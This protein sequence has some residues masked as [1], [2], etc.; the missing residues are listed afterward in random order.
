MQLIQFQ[1]P[2][3][4]LTDICHQYLILASFILLKKAASHLK[5]MAS[6]KMNGFRCFHFFLVPTLFVTCDAQRAP[7]SDVWSAELAECIDGQK[8]SGRVEL[9]VVRV[10]E[11]APLLLYGQPALAR[12]LNSEPSTSFWSLPT[13]PLLTTYP[14]FAKYLPSLLYSL[15]AIGHD[16]LWDVVLNVL[17]YN[18]CMYH[19]RDK[20]SHSNICLITCNSNFI[21]SEFLIRKHA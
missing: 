5:C 15:M 4:I 11:E 9:L 18:L 10:T 14:H 1:K 2:H 12:V 20:F 7:P 3:C 6:G 8:A 13:Q 17:S 19:H 16:P 21:E